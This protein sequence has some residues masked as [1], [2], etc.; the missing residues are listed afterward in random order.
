VIELYPQI[1]LAHVCCV[2]A[3]GLL[4][5]LRGL[6]VQLDLRI[7]MAAP[8]RYLSY[9][10]DTALL[11]SAFMLMTVLHQYPI[12]QPWLTVKV[13][14][15]VIYIILGSFA[16]K[17]AR[18]RALRLTCWIGAL[19]VFGFIITIARSHDPLGALRWLVRD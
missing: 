15:V 7:A 9:S 11:T 8:V 6:G 17:R 12:A 2:L 4:F 13:T 3:S 10:I 16:L 18:T 19:V 5:A 14:L 1:K